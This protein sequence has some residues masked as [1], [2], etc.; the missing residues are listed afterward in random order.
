MIDGAGIPR[1]HDT[2]T[3]SGIPIA[4][5]LDTDSLSTRVDEWR[6]FVASAVVT[7]EAGQTSVRLTLADSERALA[8]AVSLGQREKRCCPFFDVSIDIGP[9]DRALVLSVP[10]GAEDAMA[11]FVSALTA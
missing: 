9:E 3:T 10:E 8:D 5:N 1:A 2:C 11:A 7:V 4:C 6:T